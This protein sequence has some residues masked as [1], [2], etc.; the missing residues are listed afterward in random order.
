MKGD[1]CAGCTRH[2]GCAVHA[3]RLSCR[4]GLASRSGSSMEYC[5]HAAGP[6]PHG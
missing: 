3:G 1:W 2:A 5:L 6:C 4:S